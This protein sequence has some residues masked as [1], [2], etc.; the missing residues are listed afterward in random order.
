MKTLWQDLRYG[1][2]MLMKRPGLT[3]RDS[4]PVGGGRA[5][6]ELSARSARDE[7]RSDGR[8]EV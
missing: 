3:L 7:S 2:R 1:V 8:I 6:C 4:D 5:G